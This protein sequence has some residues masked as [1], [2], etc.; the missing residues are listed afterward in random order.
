VFAKLDLLNVG[1]VSNR[2]VNGQFFFAGAAKFGTN[3]CLSKLKSGGVGTFAAQFS[4]TNATDVLV[5]KA[6]LSTH[7][8]RL[9]TLTNDT[10][11]SASK[12]RLDPPAEP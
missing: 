12:T 1:G 7:G 4:A 2:V 3:G 9:G 8:G 10:D 5:Y 6:R 11:F